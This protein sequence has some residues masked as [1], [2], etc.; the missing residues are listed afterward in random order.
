MLWQNL[1][2]VLIVKSEN[3]RTRQLTLPAVTCRVRERL[4]KCDHR[5]LG[6]DS[7]VRV[8]LEVESPQDVS[9]ARLPLLPN[10]RDEILFS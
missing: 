5:R 1:V 6:A 4:Q 3:L 9:L 10:T 7:T 8:V 2:L